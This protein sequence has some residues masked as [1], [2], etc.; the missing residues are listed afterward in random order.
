MNQMGVKKSITTS[1]HQQGYHPLLSTLPAPM[2]NSKPDV[3]CIPDF[4]RLVISATTTEKGVSFIGGS[5]YLPY[6]PSI[7]HDGFNAIVIP[8]NPSELKVTTA[9]T[10][11]PQ[12]KRIWQLK[13]AKNCLR[14]KDMLDIVLRGIEACQGHWRDG[15][16]KENT[17]WI[18]ELE[19]SAKAHGGEQLPRR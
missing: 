9:T 15:M 10:I 12:D 17:R 7:Q 19:E 3:L 13:M 6:C 18:E 16:D 1:V 2:R 4:P 14:L 11:K 5:Y 8:T